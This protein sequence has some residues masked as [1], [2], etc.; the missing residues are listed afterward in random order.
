M[1]N[2]LKKF[3]ILDLLSFPNINPALV[4]KL[5]LCLDEKNKTTTYCSMASRT[6]CLLHAS[7]SACQNVAAS[8]HGSAYQY[9]LTCQL[10]VHWDQGVVWWKCSS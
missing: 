10:V 9:R 4:N 3:A 8:A 5:M 6:K 7:F 1:Q 2:M